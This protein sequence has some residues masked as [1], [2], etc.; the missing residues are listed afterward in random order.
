LVD[1]WK[2]HAPYK[3]L[4]PEVSQ[5]SDLIRTLCKKQKALPRSY[6]RRFLSKAQSR[7]V[8]RNEK[9]RWGLSVCAI[10]DK[11]NHFQLVKSYV[12]IISHFCGMKITDDE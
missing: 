4:S 8:I 3:I 1:G 7:A 2:V 5:L 12:D 9:E 6:G 11:K 10:Y